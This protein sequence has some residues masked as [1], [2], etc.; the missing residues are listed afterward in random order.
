MGRKKGTA[1]ITNHYEP[2]ILAM[3]SQG[4]RFEEM[5]KEINL[6][7]HNV[8]KYIE[9]IREKYDARTNPQLIAIAYQKG[10]L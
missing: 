3:L 5:A 1:H 6:Q 8:C 4:L 10:L 7:P 2:K 9:K